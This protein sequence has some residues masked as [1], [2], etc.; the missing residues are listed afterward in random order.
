MVV[1]FFCC[2]ISIKV[3]TYKCKV[4]SIQNI[5]WRAEM[6]KDIFYKKK[7][8]FLSNQNQISQSRYNWHF[9]SN[10]YFSKF[11]TYALH[12]PSPSII[13]YQIFNIFGFRFELDV[14]FFKIKQK[15]YWKVRL[16]PRQ[17]RKLSLFHILVWKMINFSILPAKYC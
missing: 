10:V 4:F 15:K 16:E 1:I 7:K 3:D 5:I 13:F 2:F 14:R 12:D 9:G 17:I 8:M 11:V 6:V